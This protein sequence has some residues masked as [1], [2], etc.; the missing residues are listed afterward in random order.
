MKNLRDEVSQS[1]EKIFTAI[2]A[3]WEKEGRL[4]AHEV[5]WLLSTVEGQL[6]AEK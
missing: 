4:D 5:E 1:T 3:K 2:K 6:K